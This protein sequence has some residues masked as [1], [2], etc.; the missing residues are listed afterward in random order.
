M[1]AK[2][3]LDRFLS[4]DFNV[5][6][7]TFEWIKRKE[8]FLSAIIADLLNPSGSHGQQHKFLNAFLQIIKRPDLKDKKLPKV[9]PQVQ[10]ALGTPD[11]LVAFENFGLVI[12]NKYGAVEQPK[13]L[14]RYHEYLNGEYGT[15]GFCLVYLTPEGDEP[16]SIEDHLKEE[17]MS[18]NKLI[19][20]S[21]RHGMLKWIEE[22]C[23]LCESDR[24]RWFLRDFMDHMNGGQTMSSSN[25]SKII[26]K[27]ALES[28]ENLETALLINSAF[29][30]DLRGQIIAGFLNELE[31]YVLAELKQRS[32]GLEWGTIID[33]DH[34]DLRDVPLKRWQRFGFG[35]TS[36]KK[37]YGVA[38]E[39]QNVSAHDVIIGV[40]REYNETTKKG[41]P[42][43]QP[44]DRLW[45]ILNDR[46]GRT[47]ELN[48]WWEW[49]CY[50]D[51][52]Y[53][54][55]GTKDGLIRLKLHE[56]EAVRHIGQELIRIIEVA[57]PI[58]DKHVRG[59]SS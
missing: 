33:T 8:D 52:P 31:K 59:S 6:K 1:Q 21:Y 53:R 56:D 23:R 2:Q 18:D 44:E 14:Q 43:F 13:Q 26:L 38:L 9:G 50:L 34:R 45:E 29:N 22:C 5:F 49:Y 37:R 46:I 12:E 51:D 54:H 17:L 4:T 11:I 36:W 55:W 57:A 35:K 32:D 20:M 19:C 3:H 16:T 25:E 48:A 39:P 28:K 42:R 15:D 24:F 41:A 7:G 58:I 40:W 10:T 30:G 47:G 27:H